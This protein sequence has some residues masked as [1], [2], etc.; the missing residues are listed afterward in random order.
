MGS[1]RFEAEAETAGVIAPPPVIFGIALAAGLLLGRSGAVG[2]NDACARGAGAGALVAGV[3][4]GASAVASLKRA[5][6]NLRP[7]R[8]STALVTSGPFRFTRNPAYVAASAIYI[9]IAL[10]VRSLPALAFLPIALVVLERGVVEREERY[11][12]RRFGDAYR[13]YRAATPRWF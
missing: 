5:G 7:D 8:P 10:T 2:R 4:L 1:A 6:T 9:G 11:L 3:V 12:E 13:A